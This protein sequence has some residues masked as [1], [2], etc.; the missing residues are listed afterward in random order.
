MTDGS[1]PLLP[2]PVKATVSH[3]PRCLP[4]L[5]RRGSLAAAP[6]A[7]LAT[8][9][10]LSTTRYPCESPF[11]C[12]QS[13]RRSKKRGFCNLRYDARARP[14]SPRSSPAPALSPGARFDGGMTPR[15]ENHVDLHR[16]PEHDSRR[17]TSLYAL[18]R[19]S[20]SRQLSLSLEPAP[21]LPEA[22]HTGLSPD[23]AAFVDGAHHFFTTRRLSTTR[24]AIM[25]SDV[26]RGLRAAPC[27]ER[28]GPVCAHSSREWNTAGSPPRGRPRT[29]SVV[30]LGA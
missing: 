11:G 6:P 19:V 30:N 2:P 20:G 5:R 8:T 13:K 1:R 24:R 4:P 7:C 18:V 25:A 23:C 3:D 29:L 27:R 15:P 10:R 12:A 28:E 21:R 17:A 14:T 26:G 9:T 16:R 22:R